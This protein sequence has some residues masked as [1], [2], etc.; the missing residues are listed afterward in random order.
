MGNSQ[1]VQDTFK[2]GDVVI[3]QVAR[4]RLARIAVTTQVDGHR[5]ERSQESGQNRFPTVSRGTDPVNEENGRPGARPPAQGDEVI[6]QIYAN[7]AFHSAKL[8]RFGVRMNG[9]VHAVHLS[10]RHIIHNDW[11]RMAGASSL[12]VVLVQSSIWLCLG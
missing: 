11:P 6:P 8:R 7:N 1:L 3:V 10:V 5:G 9:V 2:I 4:L 12:R